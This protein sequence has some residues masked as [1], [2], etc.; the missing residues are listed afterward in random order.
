MHASPQRWCHFLEEHYDPSLVND[1]V[2]NNPRCARCLKLTHSPS[3]PV[4]IETL[5][6]CLP[7]TQEFFPIMGI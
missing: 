2:S 3:S 7:L 6:F 1:S 5:H 4:C